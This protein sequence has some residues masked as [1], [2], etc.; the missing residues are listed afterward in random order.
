MNIFILCA[1]KGSRFDSIYPKPL[2]LINGKPMI[3][4]TIKSLQLD[5]V[6]KFKLFIIHNSC[7]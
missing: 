3:Y 2:N 7:C 4:Y 5:K 1:G 6:L